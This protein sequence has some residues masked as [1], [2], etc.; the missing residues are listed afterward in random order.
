LYEEEYKKRFVF[1]C[2]FGT[3]DYKYGPIT[4]GERPRLVENRGY[5]PERGVVEELL[6]GGREVVV[7]DEVPL[8]LGSGQDLAARLVYPMR[9]GIVR[10]GDDRSWRV[11][12]EL[13]YK[14]L[15]EFRP[16]GAGFK[17][18]CVVASLSAVAPLYMYERFYDYLGEMASEGL[19]RSSTI[20]PQPLAVAIAHKK[21]SCIVV[22]SGHGNTQVAP[23]SRAPIRGA[24][25]ALNRGGSEANMITAEIMKDS[26]YGDL[27]REERV[28]RMVKEGLGLLPL[29]L[30]RA[31]AFSRSQRDAV[32]GVYV[33]EGT[34]I[35]IDL[36]D[37][38][39][40]RFLIGEIVFDPNHEVFQSYFRRGMPRPS[41]VRVGD[42]VFYG[43]M[44]M[45]ETVI[46]AVERCPV[47]LQP[48]LYDQV[49]LSGGNFKWSPPPGLRGVA[50]D[51]QAKLEYMLRTKGVENVRVVLSPDP[52]FAVWRG[53]IV[54]GYAL[55]Y[56]YEW[57]WERMEGWLHFRE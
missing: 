20:I 43:M 14:S 13:L 12:R 52:Q 9:D 24:V 22:E 18:F 15:S 34:R 55:P 54:Y 28:V 32:R 37:Y 53:C 25:V 16:G 49:I 23:I 50:C 41:D 8:F 21:T 39:W 44:D 26:G 35:K 45:A 46:S 1:G 2:D 30:D 6:G 38:S 29:D 19:V 51:S 5:F 33:V 17:G 56:S 40:A 3:S 4:L 48:R 42:T 31:I 10:L 27:A 7:G 57:S 11:I 47:E 36:G